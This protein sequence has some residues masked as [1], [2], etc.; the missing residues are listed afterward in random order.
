MN[1]LNL[2][3]HLVRLHKPIGIQL[4]LWPTLM[5]L[6]FAADGRPDWH[7]VAIFVLGTVLM[8][9]A[10]CAINDYADR[11]FDK[12][13][14]RTVD[15]PLTAG[16]IHGWEALMVAGVLALASFLL[17][18]PLNTLTK[19]MSVPALIVAASYP[20]FKRFFAIPQAYLGIAFGF[21]IPMGFAAVQGQVPAAAWLMLLGNVFWSVAYDTAYAMV[22]RDDDIKLGM[23][24]SAITFGRFDVLAIMLCYVAALGIF[25]AVG[26]HF[27]LRTWFTLGMLAAAG[28]AIYHYTLIRTRD[29]AG[30]FKAFV[31]NN[32]LGALM[33]AGVAVDY[34]L[35]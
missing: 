35:R 15:R 12:H 26:W 34:A 17:I 13:V 18:L 8:R 19:Q 25:W 4:L 21:G 23:K 28:C 16:K 11:D 24:T 9:S 1:R 14:K 30:C 27:G 7:I 31:H 3:F 22:D 20:Y 5:A 10:G 33:F 29:R 6:W 2:Y 32:W